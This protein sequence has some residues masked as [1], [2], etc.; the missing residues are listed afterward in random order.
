MTVVSDGSGLIAPEFEISESETVFAMSASSGRLSVD[1]AAAS[2]ITVNA[3]G[4]LVLPE[5]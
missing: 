5:I 3:D 2:G 1:S 4:Y